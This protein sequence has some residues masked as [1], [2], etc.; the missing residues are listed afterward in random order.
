MG[1]YTGDLVLGDIH[2]YLTTWFLLLLAALGFTLWS[3]VGQYKPIQV[4]KE[5]GVVNE[6]AMDTGTHRH[7]RT[8]THRHTHAHT[9]THTHAHTHTHTHTE[10]KTTHTHTE[11]KTTQTIE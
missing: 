3:S 6:E 10:Y 1:I 5:Y 7:A 4:S 2:M 9:H 11:Y 8:H